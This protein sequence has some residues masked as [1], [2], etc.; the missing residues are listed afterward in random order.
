MKK[1]I[2][3]ICTIVLLAGVIAT[4]ARAA[5]LGYAGRFVVECDNWAKVYTVTVYKWQADAG[6][7]NNSNLDYGCFVTDYS[8]S[9]GYKLNLVWSSYGRQTAWVSR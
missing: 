7:W 3:A 4:P 5:D 9:D 1:L 8:M 6:I 2:T